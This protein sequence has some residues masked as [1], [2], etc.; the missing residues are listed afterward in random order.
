MNR[1][2]ESRYDCRETSLAFKTCCH[3]C[4]CCC[5]SAALLLFC[6]TGAQFG[7]RL[8]SALW[9]FEQGASKAGRDS[10]LPVWTWSVGAGG[11]PQP[12]FVS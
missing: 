4:C 2:K 12:K 10:P 8:T 11:G 1:W 5:C 3:C 6:C 7:L 9:F